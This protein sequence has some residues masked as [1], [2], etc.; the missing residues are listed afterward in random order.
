MNRV[1]VII[2]KSDQNYSAYLP[3]LDGCIATGQDI[4]ETRAQITE[5]VTF[6]LEGLREAGLTVPEVFQQDFEFEFKLDVNT[7]FEY[8][9]GIL[10]KV[11]LS[12][13]TGMNQSLISQYANGMKKPSRKQIKK[14]QNAIHHFAEELLE[15]R[16]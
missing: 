3:V 13:L 8:F 14:I 11:G 16:L 9:A 2:E 1:L 5:A 12:R 4:H 7:L 10:T 15:V 6:H